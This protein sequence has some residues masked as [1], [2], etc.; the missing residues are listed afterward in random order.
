MPIGGH[1]QV[2][3]PST[4]VNGRE[5]SQPLRSFAHPPLLVS[6]AM[7]DDASISVLAPIRGCFMAGYVETSRR[8]H[9]QG[10]HHLCPAEV[11]DRRGTATG[12]MRLGCHGR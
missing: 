5:P 2:M 3:R 8:R 4:T 6:N 12:R 10:W 7:H 1:A 9:P 11:H